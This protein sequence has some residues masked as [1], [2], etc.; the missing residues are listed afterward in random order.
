MTIGSPKI[1]WAA[2]AYVVASIYYGIQ[3]IKNSVNPLPL[4]VIKRPPLISKIQTQTS[5]RYEAQGS[6]YGLT[7]TP[8]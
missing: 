3:D 4:N 1:Q 7:A 2:S 5:L 8:K 6:L